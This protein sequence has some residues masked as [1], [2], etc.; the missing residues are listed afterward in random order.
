MTARSTGGK[1]LVAVVVIVAAGAVTTHALVW[2]TWRDIIVRATH[3]AAA[4]HAGAT[5]TPGVGTPNTTSPRA[6]G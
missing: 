3:G 1:V 6:G 5:T 4:S 2:L